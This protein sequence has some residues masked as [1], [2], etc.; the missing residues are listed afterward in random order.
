[1]GDL[2]LARAAESA[3][4]FAVALLDSLTLWTA[5]RMDDGDGTL[6]EL[7]GFIDAAQASGT[8]FVVVSDEVG[9]GVVPETASGRAFRDLLGL[10]NAQVAIAAQEVHLC[11]AGVGIRIK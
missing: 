10:A 7:A 11:V 9:L 3:A 1:V 4:D 2:P 5:A 8:R 6:D